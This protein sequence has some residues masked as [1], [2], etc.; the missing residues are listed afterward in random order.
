MPQSRTA[1][2][3]KL[4][5]LAV[6]VQNVPGLAPPFCGGCGS[7][8]CCNLCLPVSQL[9]VSQVGGFVPTSWVPFSWSAV[10]TLLHRLLSR[11]HWN[12]SA[13]L[14]YGQGCS[15]VKSCLSLRDGLMLLQA[16][17]LMFRWKYKCMNEDALNCD[18]LQKNKQTFQ[19][20]QIGM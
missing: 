12:F 5:W 17:S 15:Q 19:Q 9:L 2:G 4:V 20:N 14:I 8:S 6:S 16:E 10:D 13:F 7:V 3:M 18:I 1:Q 11:R